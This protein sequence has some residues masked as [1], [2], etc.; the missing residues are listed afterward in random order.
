MD[1][2]G[3]GHR[4]AEPQ[5]ALLVVTP[6]HHEADFKAVARRLKGEDIPVPADVVGGPLAHD[7]SAR[8]ELCPLRRRGPRL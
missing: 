4:V 7:S 2:G 5:V 8:S 6:G 1:V 3:E